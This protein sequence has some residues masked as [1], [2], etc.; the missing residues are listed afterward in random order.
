M[1]GAKGKKKEGGQDDMTF[2]QKKEI[3]QW[4]TNEVGLWLSHVR[5][6]KFRNVFFYNEI[7]GEMLLDI[8]D[9]DLLALP[10]DRLG[11]RKKILRKVNEL[12]GGPAGSSGSSKRNTATGSISEAAP[13]D[14]AS[15]NSQA[16]VGSSATDKNIVSIKC[17]FNEDVRTLRVNIKDDY[18]TF[19]NKIRNEYGSRR[20]MAKFRDEDGDL[21]TIRNNRDVQHII[22]LIQSK[23]KI[24]LIIFE[25]RSSSDKKK[26]K[27]SKSKRSKESSSEASI[28][29]EASIMENFMDAVVVANRRGQI[30]FFNGAAED[31]FGWDREDVVGQNVTMLMNEN[32]A[33]N[34]SKYL[35]RY[36]R[37]GNPRVIGKGR[38]VVGVDKDGKKIDLWLSLT[39]S[40]ETYTA[41]LRKVETGDRALGAKA[42]VSA[43]VG[44]AFAVFDSYPKP[45]VVVDA[46]GVIHYMNDAISKAFSHDAGSL[47]GQGIS[48]LSPGIYSSE[49]DDLLSDF[50]YSV[51]SG[52]KA[53][54]LT[55]NN[56]RDVVCYSK[57]GTVMPAIVDFSH[58]S[59]DDED[60]VILHFVV[61]SAGGAADAPVLAAQ[62]AVIANLAIPGIV[63]NGHAIIQELNSSARSM[64]GYSLSEVLGKNVKMLIP[65]GETY[66]N[67]DEWIANYAKTGKTRSADGVSKV[68]GKGRDVVGMAKDKRRL[69]LNLSVTALEEKNGERVFTGI[70]QLLG[71]DEMQ[72]TDSVVLQQ[73][74]SV[75]DQL[76]I[77]TCIITHDSKIRAFNTAAQKLFGY[78]PKEVLGQDVT[79]LMPLGDVR[80]LHPTFI[81]KF[82]NGD[83]KAADSLVVGKG[84]K[85]VARHKNG[86]NFST[87]LSVTERRDG[88][89]SV[90]TGVFS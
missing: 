60:Y 85:V 1:F 64:F 26:K 40:N 18:E 45:T 32:D 39:E 78:G 33:R 4:T 23:V 74:I 47:V 49:G 12:R 22:G 21:V 73:Q 38:Q 11:E 7:D 29:A 34:H 66:D 8:D 30:R 77:P 42:N 28:D 20:M 86:S 13:S 58:R 50:L 76:L 51:E 69:K 54:L 84:R 35:R 43:A 36:R 17:V 46:D 19:K 81:S 5:L 89:V 9:D 31:L 57:S 27:K 75:V 88:K 3:A 70:F 53:K 55:A 83:K 41:I 61:D 6:D 80:K 59:L 2:L 72:V 14:T 79:V 24:R 25:E 68:V 44:Q 10:I 67:H 90:Y 16:S 52:K 37:E 82:H 48:V 62:R 71:E 15:N 56:Q 87:T 65:P 63:M